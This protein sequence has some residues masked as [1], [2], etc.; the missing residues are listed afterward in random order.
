VHVARQADDFKRLG[1]K[2]GVELPISEQ[3]H[4]ILHQGKAPKDAIR[5]LMTRPGRDE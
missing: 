5:E 3:M 2:Y 4:A 1:K